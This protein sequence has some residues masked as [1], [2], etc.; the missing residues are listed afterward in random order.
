VFKSLKIG[1]FLFMKNFLIFFLAMLLLTG[2]TQLEHMAEKLPFMDTDNQNAKNDASPEKQG[3][4]R[5]TPEE[6]QI[7]DLEILP[8]ESSSDGQAS[9]ESEE[10]ALEAAFFNDIREVDGKDVI[11][12]PEN[13]LVMVN[14]LF[15]LPSSYTPSDLVKPEVA[16]SFGEQELEKSFLREEAAKALEKMF[17]AAKESGIEIF[18]VS[19]YRSYVR[20][21][22]IL[23]AEIQNVGE[24]RAVAAVAV[25]GNS[26]HQTGLAMDISARSVGLNLVEQFGQTEEGKWL[27]ENAHKFGF[28][29]RYPNGKE[30]ITGYMYEP[31]HFRYVGEKSAAEIHKNNWT[32][33]EYF[34]IVKKL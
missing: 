32:L 4:E 12:N 15:S 20:Q 5:V 24:D 10:L 3:M 1:G 7:S 6:T 26:E 16:F 31:W 19:G 13:V 25:P 17:A 27:A 22:Q 11:Q 2:C 9:G 28:I 14:K 29:L 23:Q 30:E 21:D 18:A 34:Q 33:E 8:N